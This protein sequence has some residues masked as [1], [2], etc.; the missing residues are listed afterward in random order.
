MKTLT[1]ARVA[2]IPGFTRNPEHDFSDDGNRFIGFEYK[3]LPLTQHRDSNYGTFLSFRVDYIAHKKGFTYDDYFSTPWYHLCDKYNG[4]SE[5]P[6]IEEIVKDL[7]TV[8]AGI[9]ELE[10]KV[11]N[12]TI[13]LTKVVERAKFEKKLGEETIENFKSK[14]EWWK[15][16]S[17]YDL[18]NARDYL[19]RLQHEIDNLEKLIENPAADNNIRHISQK[20]AKGWYIEIKENEFYIKWLNEILDKQAA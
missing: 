8:I 1:E 19:N 5:L 6:E 10:K 14:F 7:E 12:E 9:A 17:D 16:K 18:R 3:G 11:K 13:D 15:C 20:V 4:V 2:K